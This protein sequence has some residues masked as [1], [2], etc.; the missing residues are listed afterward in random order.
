MTE[1]EL[2]I[3]TNTS[4]Y[5]HCIRIFSLGR[6]GRYASQ[7]VN[8]SSLCATQTA[9]INAKHGVIRS[10][11]IR[12]S[13]STLEKSSVGAIEAVGKQLTGEKY[14]SITMQEQ[15]IQPQRDVVKWLVEVMSK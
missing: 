14:G 12:V 6:S 9:E 10:C 11:A 3:W 4:V 7:L 15:T 5:I 8:L 13:D 1:L 2:G